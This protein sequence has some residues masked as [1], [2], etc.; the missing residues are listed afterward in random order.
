MASVALASPAQKRDYVT[1]SDIHYVTEIVTVQA[2]SPESKLYV[3]RQHRYGRHTSTST[4]IV[5]ASPEPV[6]AQ[7]EPTL[8]PEPSPSPVGNTEG[9][10]SASQSPSAEPSTVPSQTNA[11]IPTAEPEPSPTSKQPEPSPTPKETQSPVSP[12][13]NDYQQTCLDHHNQH[14]SNHSAP[15]MAWDSGLEHS[16]RVVAQTCVFKHKM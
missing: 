5:T 10:E 14:R 1:I 13:G 2:P 15:P 6:P 12:T 8:S 7:P 3:H 4:V 16:A 11:V 9:Q